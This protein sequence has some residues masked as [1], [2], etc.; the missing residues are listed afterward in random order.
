MASVFP[1][2]ASSDHLGFRHGTQDFGSQLHGDRP[3]DDRLFAG[4]KTSITV[5]S[6]RVRFY[7]ISKYRFFAL[8]HGQ[9]RLLRF[10]QRGS[11]Y[12]K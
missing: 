11:C 6:S 12:G 4:D 8:R 5:T 7:R 3:F 10:H 1:D 2:A 9:L